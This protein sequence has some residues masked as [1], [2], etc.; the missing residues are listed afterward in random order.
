M[1]LYTVAHISD[2][3]LKQLKTISEF[4]VVD[5]LPPVGNRGDAEGHARRDTLRYLRSCSHGDPTDGECS[6]RTQAEG[7]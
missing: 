3:V 5:F 1:V 4:A 6:T 7:R 2:A